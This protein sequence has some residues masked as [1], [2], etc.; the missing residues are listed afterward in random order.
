MTYFIAAWVVDN[1]IVTVEA[2]T[3]PILENHLPD[4]SFDLRIIAEVSGEYQDAQ[5][6]RDVIAISGET[7][8]GFDFVSQVIERPSKP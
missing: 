8:T 3:L 5:Q 7:L 2:D 6:V 1:E 4:F